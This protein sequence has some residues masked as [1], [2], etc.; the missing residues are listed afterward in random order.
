MLIEAMACGCPVVATDAPGGSREVLEDGRYGELVAVGDAKGLAGALERALEGRPDREALRRRAQDF[1]VDAG[2]TNT[3]A[4][5][6]LAER[7]TTP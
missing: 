3:L 5:L 7:A 1:S 4:T 6:G 2:V